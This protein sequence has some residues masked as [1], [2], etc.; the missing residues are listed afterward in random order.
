MS[1][2]FGG[3]G[4]QSTSEKRLNAIQLQQ[5]AY[6]NAVPLVYGKLRASP[7]LVW[8]G[9]FTATA[10]PP[11][12][13]GKGGGGGA[14]STSYTSSAAMVLALAEGPI[15][16][17]GNVWAD[18]SQNSLSSLGFTLFTGAGPQ[19]T[20]SYLTTN[21][22]TQAI[23]YDNTAYVAA[24]S[25]Q[26][27]SSAALPNLSFEVL[28]LFT[29]ATING[30]AEPY[31]VLVDYCTEPNHGAGFS[32][33]ATLT[34]ANSYQQYCKAVGLTLSPAEFTQ[35]TAADF[36]GEVLRA[37]NSEAVWTASGTLKVVP[38]ADAAVSGNG[39]TYTPGNGAGVGISTPIYSLD[40]NAYVAGPDEDPVLMTSKPAANLFNVINVEF[41]DRANQYNTATAQA[42]D[43]ADI[44]LNGERVAPTISLHSITQLSVARQVAQFELSKALYYPN[45]YEFRA[46]PDYQL[47]E[48]MD[49]ISITEST[50]GLS[51]TLCRVVRVEEAGD[52]TDE[53]KFTVEELPLGPGTLPQ[54]SAQAGLGYSA[55]Y[56]T[57]PG[58]VQAPVIFAAPPALV[59]NVGGYQLWLAVAGPSGSTTWGGCNVYM[60]LDGGTTYASI[61]Q[62]TSGARYG[63]LSAA[64]AT[65]TDPDT[66]NTLSVTLNNTAA[67]RRPR[68][69]CT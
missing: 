58:S 27:G 54:Y 21:Y 16:S 53:L 24:S 67:T 11:S 17:V 15:T 1:G 49:V 9:S 62:I 28:G 4:G 61:G 47:L 50:L 42:K 64:F 37:T 66:T 8:Y 6:G 20:W 57:A 51:N 13:G 36:I 18:K 59:S 5:S 44:A 23:P 60:S 39:A 56:S 32:Y 48:P 7:I 69:K 30:D 22:P 46:L 52:D 63:T 25:L 10:H 35:R 55:N 26:L 34:G 38:R 43:D 45:Q 33:L 3:G 40:D 12:Q 2:L 14:T 29:D 68:P 19:A 31:N 65:G 41:L